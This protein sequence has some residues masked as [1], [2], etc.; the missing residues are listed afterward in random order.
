MGRREKLTRKQFWST[1][2]EDVAYT[3]KQLDKD[4]VNPN[5]I[6]LIIQSVRD[7]LPKMFP[8]RYA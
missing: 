2:D 8:D 4:V 1:A 5:Q 3:G 6:R 7:H